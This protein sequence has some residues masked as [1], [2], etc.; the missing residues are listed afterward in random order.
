ML[1]TNPFLVSA[2]YENFDTE[3]L[4]TEDWMSMG[5][6]DLNSIDPSV[7]PDTVL[8]NRF[9]ELNSQQ[10]KDLTTSQLKLVSQS[11]WGDLGQY[12]SGAMQSALSQKYPSTQ[13][14]PTSGM[15]IDDNGILKMA[16]GTTSDLSSFS[17]S[18]FTVSTPDGVLTI[19]NPTGTQTFTGGTN[20]HA[21]TVDGQSVDFF[22]EFKYVV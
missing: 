14:T 18:G 15:T 4:K 19:T 21:E 6:A 7:I 17:G 20:V 3:D 16:D 8:K 22:F 5:S 11:Q 2:A 12:N 1:I 10:R 13:I 9:N